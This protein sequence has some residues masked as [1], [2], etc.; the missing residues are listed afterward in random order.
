MPLEGGVKESVSYLDVQYRQ[1]VPINRPCPLFTEDPCACAPYATCA[2]C[3]ACAPYAPY[4]PYASYL[5]SGDVLR[6]LRVVVEGGA[7]VRYRGA[8]GDQ[9]L[10]RR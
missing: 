10:S 5:S 4:A 2:T 1:I 6:H 9:H 3:V 8:R 7:E